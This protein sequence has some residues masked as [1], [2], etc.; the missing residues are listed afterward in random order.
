[1]SAMKELFLT[2][3][4]MATGCMLASAGTGGM[5]DS[6]KN[7]DLQYSGFVSWCYPGFNFIEFLQ[8]F[9]LNSANRANID[10]QIQEKCLLKTNRRRN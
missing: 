7:P 2:W 4:F 5:K 9:A 3:C 10:G 1:M 8:T 6:G